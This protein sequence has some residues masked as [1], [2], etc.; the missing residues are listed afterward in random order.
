MKDDLT[1]E[2]VNGLVKKQITIRINIKNFINLFK[3]KKK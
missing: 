2:Q 1:S 3:K